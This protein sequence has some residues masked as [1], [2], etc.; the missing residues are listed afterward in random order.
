MFIGH[1]AVGFAAKKLATKPSLGTYFL[2]VTFL[3]VLWPIFLVLGFEHVA[4]EPGNT[5]FTPLN[6]ISYPYSHSLLMTLVWATLFTLAYNYIRR[7]KEGAKILWAAVAS[8]WVLDAI[9]HRADLPLFPGSST[10]VGFG[11][12]NSIIGTVVIEGAMFVFS[13][14]LYEEITKEKNKVGNFS[15]WGFVSVMTVLYIMNINGPLPPNI[16]ALKWTAIGAWL[17]LAWG[18]WIDKNRE[19]KTPQVE[20]VEQVASTPQNEN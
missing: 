2:A 20:A 3:D 13:V 19:L 15:F 14:F 1:F 12:W 8:H 4:I 11:L 18:Y 10:F 6:F 7:D 17:F 9:T 5:A 16:T